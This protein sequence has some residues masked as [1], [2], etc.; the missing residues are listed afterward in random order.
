[1]VESIPNIVIKKK[2]RKFYWDHIVGPIVTD[3]IPPAILCIMALPMSA[4][5]C[6]YFYTIKDSLGFC[7]LWVINIIIVYILMTLI[8][9][10]I[11]DR[12]DFA[13]LRKLQQKQDV[14]DQKDQL[15]A[16]YELTHH[17]TYLPDKSN[18][19]RLTFKQHSRKTHTIRLVDVWNEYWDKQ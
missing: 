10:I 5:F 18:D 15:I 3:Y 2:Y 9:N 11:R 8:A 6:Y 19:K 13:L 4:R 14:C 16:W 12:G 7:V 1:M 17:C